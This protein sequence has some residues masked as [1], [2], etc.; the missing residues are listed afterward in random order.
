V[1]ENGL[2][3]VVVGLGFGGAFSAIYLD[4]PAVSRVAVCERDERRLHAITERHEFADVFTDLEKV[5]RCDYDA[6]HL[7]TGIPD[8]ARQALA[9]LNAGKHCACTVPMATSLDDFHAV[10][11]AQRRSGCS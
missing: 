9:V 4:H 6:V 10:V 2:S 8:H 11:E 7:V 3:V 1:S 5:L